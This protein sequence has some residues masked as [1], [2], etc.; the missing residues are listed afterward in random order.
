MKSHPAR[1]A[2]PCFRLSAVALGL[3][4]S[5]MVLAEARIDPQL[6]SRLA[7]ASPGDELQIVIS[8]EQSAPPSAIQVAALQTLGIDKGVTMRALP[9]A[10]ALATPAEIQA[11]AQRDDVASIYFNAPLRYFNQE[12]RE[13]TGVARAQADPGQYRQAIPYSGRG[14]TVLV[15]DSG[16]DATHA[17]L[18]YG[19]RVVQNVLGPQ[20]ILAELATE[21]APGIVPVTYLEGIP[22]T[23]LGSGHGTHCAGTVGGSGE[24]SG[25]LYRGVAPD[26]DLVGYG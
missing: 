3:V 17:D 21:F 12:A 4:A 10:G 5:G 15:N 19:E 18:Q 8:F 20:N 13:L 9:I 22:N 7:T 1:G 2:R 14:V 24:R 16:I 26:A 6:V 23:D 25:G 11:L